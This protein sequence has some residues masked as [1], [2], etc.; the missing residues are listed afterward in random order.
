M[1]PAR[2]SGPRV[3]V[4]EFFRCKAQATAEQSCKKMTDDGAGPVLSG[5]ALVDFCFL[6]SLRFTMHKSF[7][8]S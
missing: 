5:A 1:S 2:P 3:F 8:Q 4:P 6:P 7:P